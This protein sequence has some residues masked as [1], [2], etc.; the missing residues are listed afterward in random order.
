[1]LLSLKLLKKEI[2]LSSLVHLKDHYTTLGLHPSASMDEIKRAYRRLALELHP[3]KKGDDPYAAARFAAVK[4]AYETLTDPL[5]KA[6]YLQERWYAQ[7]TGRLSTKQ[8]ITPV[9]ILKQLLE[10]DKYTSTLDTHRMNTE[11][12]YEYMREIL[13]DETIQTVNSFKE[14]AINKEIILAALK[15][16]Q[17]LNYPLAVSLTAQLKKLNS[18]EPAAESIRHFIRQR[19]QA[20]YW[21]KKRVWIILIIAIILCLGIFFIEKNQH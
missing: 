15:S 16:G 6:W 8:I 11:G 18:D 7:S 10:L 3:D 20:N 21:E 4:E 1:M 14:P 2:D 17:L 13:S 5:K 9:T 12:L 19:Q